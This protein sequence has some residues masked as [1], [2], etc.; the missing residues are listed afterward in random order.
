MVTAVDDL[1]ADGIERLQPLVNRFPVETG[2]RL[3]ACVIGQMRDAVAQV[4]L[5]PRQHDHARREILRSPGAG[6]NQHSPREF[7]GSHR[8]SETGVRSLRRFRSV[9]TTSSRDADRLS[10]F[11]DKL[12]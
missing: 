9:T 3:E 6:Q 7:P 11:G 1:E 4:R 2:N 10:S 8:S 5:D 12:S